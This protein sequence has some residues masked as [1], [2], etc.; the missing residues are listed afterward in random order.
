MPWNNM[1]PHQTIGHY[2]IASK[3]GEGGMGAVYRATD[4]RLNRDVA[5]KVL[6]PA[7]AEDSARMQRFEREAQVLASLN[8]PNIAAIYGIEQ[9]AIVMELVEGADLAGPLPVDTVIDYAKQIAAGLEA[10]HERGIIHRDLK[11]ANIKVTHDGVVKILDF[12]LAKAS[13]ASSAPGS[14]TQSP[15]MS[16]AMTQA[17]MILGTAAYM[18]PEQ[19]KGKPVDRRADIWAFGVILFELLTGRSLY[20]AQETVTETLAAV[21]LKDPDY[22]ALPT[23]TP[24]RLKRL[25][26]RCMRKDPKL[27]LRDIGEARILLDEPEPPPTPPVSSIVPPA[28]P[29]KTG[30]AVA[31]IFGV[32]ALVAGAGWWRASRA[33][34]LPMIRVS[35]DLGPD[36]VATNR[37]TAAISPDGTRIVFHVRSNGTTVLAT[38]LMH[39]AQAT[40]LAGTEGARDPFFKPD[41]QWIGFFGGGKLRKIS[42]QGGAAVDLCDV[43]G[44]DRGGSWGDDGT[45]VATLDVSHLFRIPEAGGTPQMVPLKTKSDRAIS[46]RGA[47]VLPGSET[48]I[49]TAGSVGSF[50]SADI[51]AVSLKTGD[52]KV[53]VHGGYWGRYLPSGH[54]TYIHQGT[55]FAVPFDV[56]RLEAHGT[57]VPVQQEIA[58]NITNGGG[59]VEFSDN[60]TMVYLSGKS[61]GVVRT[62][63]WMDAAGKK[64]SLL[65]PQGGTNTPR[66]SPDGKRLA[67]SL[68]GNI[69]ILDPQR[70][71][72][73]KI[74]FDNNSNSPVW[75]PDGKHIAYSGDG[76]IWWTRADGSAQPV[77]IVEKGT[78]WSF[79]PDGHRL[80]ITQD[81]GS[82]GLDISTLP[83]DTTDPDHPKAGQPE[84]F[85]QTPYGKTAPAFS[86]DGRWIAYMS[87][88]SGVGQ[89]YV[90]PFPPKASGG[91]WQVS[92]APGT[93]PM[94]SRTSKELFYETFDSRIWVADY[95]AAGETFSPGKPRL[96]CDTPIIFTGTFPNLDLAPDGQ[97]F[98]VFPA[99]DEAGEGKAN[100]H[101]MFLFHF[102][103]ELKRTVK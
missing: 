21:V 78:P 58:S 46:Y 53:V 11:P 49:A 100:V 30:W 24:P 44:G 22:S 101:V 40:L 98:V 12:G 77:R 66:L 32:I 88:E 39:Q 26:E 79:S 4:T 96:W 10:A 71:A 7:F 67:F 87:S 36:A 95:T 50:D 13:E 18:S 99:S 89:I 5:I 54:L 47:Q 23:D 31:G 6:P 38:R 2:R 45:I 75:T 8:H 94:W 29:R 93:F 43:G 90:R 102:F 60:G 92:T 19:A 64:T 42:V 25:I 59:N 81:G 48:V 55:L 80:A 9:G 34:D 27:R 83:I 28:A 14:N 37:V 73:V 91:K 69:S 35:A 72:I 86:P 52:V 63:A 61:S 65:T 76:G 51:V 1:S 68:N 74:T 57:P 97:R 41:G 15:T 33:P 16:L 62:I 3:L 70:D 84:L 85:L 82:S 56:K 103:D 20:G 17:G